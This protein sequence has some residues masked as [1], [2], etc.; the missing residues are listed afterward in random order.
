MDLIR[1]RSVLRAGFGAVTFLAG[2]SFIG[3]DTGARIGSG[4][5]EPTVE[6]VASGRTAVS[7]AENETTVSVTAPPDDSHPVTARTVWEHDGRSLAVQQSLLDRLGL[8]EGEQVRLRLG[9][10]QVAV[11][12]VAAVPDGDARRTVWLDPAGLKRL[13]ARGMSGSVTGTLRTP[14]PDDFRTVTEARADGGF[15]EQVLGEGERVAVLAPH[16]GYVEPGTDR[17]AARTAGLLPKATAWLGQGWRPGGG[18]YDRWHVTSTAL[19]PASYP[20]LARLAP[21]EY[22][23]AVSYH[24]FT[25]R[26]ILVGGAA[27][28]SLR[29]RVR[30]TLASVLDGD[31]RVRLAPDGRYDGDHPSNPV[32]W[33]P[34]DGQGGVQIEQGRDVRSEHWDTVAESVAS[35]LQQA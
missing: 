31:V 20:G 14:V 7:T 4:G 17:Q 3:D 25:G 24:G 11:Y 30:G 1:R 18:A 26:G 12:S 2:V 28:R 8:D 10:D 15:V 34:K 9:T 22:E 19:H 29:R 27:D 5:T 21:G 33:L 32:N 23:Y 13:E 6:K 16:G 35:A